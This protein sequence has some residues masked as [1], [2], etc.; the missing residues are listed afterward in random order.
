M[1]KP[2]VV[3]YLIAVSTLAGLLLVFV[4]QR[5]DFSRFLFGSPSGSNAFL[6]NR[7]IRFLINDGLALGLLYSLFPYRRYMKFA[8]AVQLLGVLLFLLPYFMIKWYYPSYNGPMINFIHRLIIN[9]V[10]LIMLIPAFYYQRNIE[11]RRGNS[12]I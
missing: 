1:K 3:R 7:S 11:H 5:I 2:E 9:P 10:L 4:Y 12:S 8:V 6:I